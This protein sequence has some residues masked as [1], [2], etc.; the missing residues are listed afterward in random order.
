M[1]IKKFN[2]LVKESASVNESMTLYR[3]VP[4]KGSE[5]LNV[6]DPGKY[7]VASKSNIKDITLKGKA[8]DY[9]LVTIKANTDDVD[10]SASE[11]ETEIQGSKVI[12]L[13]SGAEKEIVKIEPYKMS[14]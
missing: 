10:Q 1:I 8:N 2:Q 6:N 9:Y 11:K 14:A 13:K 12:A 7:Y 5:K 4:L 3:V